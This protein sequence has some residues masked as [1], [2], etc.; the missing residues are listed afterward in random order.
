MARY[1]CSAHGHTPRSA[2]RQRGGRLRGMLRNRN[3]FPD[4]RALP[5]VSHSSMLI[6]PGGREGGGGGRERKIPP[7]GCP[8]ARWGAP[9]SLRSSWAARGLNARTPPSSSPASTHSTAILRCRAQPLRRPGR[10]RRPAASAARGV[11]GFIS[12]RRRQ[13]QGICVAGHP[14]KYP[15]ARQFGNW[16]TDLWH[17]DGWRLGWPCR[18]GKGILQVTA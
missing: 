16:D 18:N 3:M 13:W 7:T 10:R 5:P 1:G 4:D 14:A 11:Y 12:C 8:R 15:I 9:P 6:I 2:S 17:S